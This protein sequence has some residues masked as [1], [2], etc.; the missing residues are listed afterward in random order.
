MKSTRCSSDSLSINDESLMDGDNLTADVL[1]VISPVLASTTPSLTTAVDLTLLNL[2][3]TEA[4]IYNISG[5]LQN[6]IST[7]GADGVLS[8]FL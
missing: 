7:K 4:A 2:L 1:A 5:F 6:P 3:T 8:P